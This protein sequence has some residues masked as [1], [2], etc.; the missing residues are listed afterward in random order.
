MAGSWSHEVR[1]KNDRRHD[2]VGE[3]RERG[4]RCSDTEE[5]EEGEIEEEG[6]AKEETGVEMGRRARCQR[7]RPTAKRFSC[8]PSMFDSLGVQVPRTT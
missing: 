1:K 5:S 2:V 8:V 3:P 7:L 6:T 4:G